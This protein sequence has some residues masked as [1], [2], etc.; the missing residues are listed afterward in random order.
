MKI[1]FKMDLCEAAEK[2]HFDT[3]EYLVSEGA[4]VDMK[5]SAGMY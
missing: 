2:R 4:S 5:N 1:E 3:V